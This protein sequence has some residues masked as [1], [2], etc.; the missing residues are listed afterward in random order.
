MVVFVCVCGVIAG[1][2]LCNLV[3]GGTLSAPP[4]HL[5]HTHRHRRR[6]KS[7]SLPTAAQSSVAVDRPSA[8]FPASNSR[9]VIIA[10]VSAADG[11]HLTS[12]PRS[13]SEL[14]SST[15]AE[16]N[17]AM[18]RVHS[19][20]HVTVEVENDKD[21]SIPPEIVYRRRRRKLKKNVSVAGYK[22]QNPSSSR[23]SL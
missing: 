6:Y 15:A 14:A 20:S 5:S 19:A 9:R 21:T 12:Q 18:P 4:S 22:Q 11:Q 8:G 2:C 23:E 7:R 10:S 13:A 3:A 1:L 17:E 16:V